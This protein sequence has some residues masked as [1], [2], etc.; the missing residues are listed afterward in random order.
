[1]RFYP[2]GEVRWQNGTIPT[3]R[4]FTSQLAE[5]TGLGSLMNYNAR[6]YSPL[7]GRFI[8]ADTIVPKPGNP[9]SFNRYSYVEN[10]P[11]GAVDLSGHCSGSLSN[12]DSSDS[13]C[14]SLYDQT[15]PYFG[16]DPDGLYKWGNYELSN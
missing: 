11:L 5:P 3:D 9:N 1:M 12:R 14:W 8:S 10:S 6:E 16:Y 15:T 7:L 2:F 4:T 13:V